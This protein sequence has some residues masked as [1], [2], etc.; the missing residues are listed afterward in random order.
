[1]RSS[2]AAGAVVL[3]LKVPVVLLLKVPVVLLLKVPATRQAVRYSC[4]TCRITKLLRASSNMLTAHVVP[5]DA[6]V[7]I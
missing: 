5:P 2:S 1:M 3:L 7:V 4:N 6:H